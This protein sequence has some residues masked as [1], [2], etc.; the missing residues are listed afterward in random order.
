MVDEQKQPAVTIF[1][2]YSHRDAGLIDPV[3]RLLQAVPGGG[4]GVF[5]DRI[6]ITPGKKWRPIVM[7][8]LRDA[9]LVVVF[10]CAHSK[11]SVE[12]AREYG[13]AIQLD[14]DV[15]PVLLDSTPLPPA[16]G[17]YE[18][19]DFRALAERSHGVDD[20]AHTAATRRR[21]PSIRDISLA[22][23]GLVATALVLTLWV[24]LPKPKGPPV[25]VKEQSVLSIPSLIA[26][27]II[28]IIILIINKLKEYSIFYAKGE[29]GGPPAG[30]PAVAGAMAEELRSHLLSRAAG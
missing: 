4:S 24:V 13:E 17:D 3:V 5:Q 6:G 15:V 30:G 22:L 25:I 20:A 11:E 1:V 18:W 29:A 8:A 2:S 16:L 28:G 14:K 19:V 12:C 7:A 9:R 27:T 10:W 21:F 26:G 23:L